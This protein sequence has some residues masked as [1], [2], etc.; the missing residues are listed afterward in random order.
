VRYL[1]ASLVIGT[2]YAYLTYRS[3]ARRLVFI[4]L[5]IVVPI[6]ANWARAYM[7]VMIGHLS[8]NKLAV[9]VDHLIYGW[10][11]FGIVIL[12][13]FWIGAHWRDDGVAT[14]TSGAVARMSGQAASPGELLLVAVMAGIVTAV[15][16][17]GSQMIERSNA[18]STP[19]LPAIGAVGAWHSAAGGLT[20]WRPQ[21]QNPSSEL[22]ET[23]SRDNTAIGLYVGYY[24]NQ[25]SSRK[26]VSSDNALVKSDGRAWTR[27]GSGTRPIVV[28]GHPVDAATTELRGPAGKRLVVRR[29]YWIDGRLTASDARAKGYIALSQLMGRGDDAAVV[30]V[31]AA[32]DRPG[33]ADAALDTFIR[34]AGPAIEAMLTMTRDRR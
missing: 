23:F 11:F 25:N 13:M 32:M 6:V 12:L 21:F 33:E 3:Q 5:S 8:G 15:W 10:L 9:G 19:A 30:M 7:I 17:L 34:D 1:I 4:G 26:L 14:E 22:H 27:V 16:P 18:A 31:Y 2:L 28:Y 20:T 24:R 29:W